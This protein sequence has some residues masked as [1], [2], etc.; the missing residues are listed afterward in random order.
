MVFL[1]FAI[2]TGPISEEFGWRGLALP[3]LQSLHSPL[4][5][6]MLVGLLWGL[7][8]TGPDFWRLLLGGN[9]A[10]FLYPL[11]ITG[12]T[13]PLSILFTW[14]YNNTGGSLICPMLCHASFNST[15]LLLSLVWEGRWSFL[16]GAELVMGLWLVAMSVV[17]LGTFRRTAPVFA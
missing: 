13:L 5:A 7:W 16:I 14:M 17:L 15:L 8:H 6:S 9:P 12:G 11:A 1:F 2:P 10:A 4:G 3:R